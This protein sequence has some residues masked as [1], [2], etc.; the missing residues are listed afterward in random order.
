MVQKESQGSRAT[1]LLDSL[2]REGDP[3]KSWI[4][5]FCCGCS[6]GPWDM[7][8]AEDQAAAGL[9]LCSESLGGCGVLFCQRFNIFP[10][11]QVT[12]WAQLF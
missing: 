1:R 6:P 9:S 3:R 8:T 4:V 7:R 10:K 12:V 11:I 2:C 5:L